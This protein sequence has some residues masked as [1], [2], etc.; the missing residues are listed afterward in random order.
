MEKPAWL[1]FRL[2]V[3]AVERIL[4]TVLGVDPVARVGCAVALAEAAAAEIRRLRLAL[5][6]KD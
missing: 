6:R 5:E 2:Q 4:G 1:R 3:G